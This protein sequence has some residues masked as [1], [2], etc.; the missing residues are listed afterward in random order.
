MTSPYSLNWGDSIYAKVKATNIV[1]DSQ[2]SVEGNGAVILTKPDAPV[3]LANDGATTS[4]TTIAMTWSEGAANGGTPVIDYR[5]KYKLSSDAIYTTLVTGITTT[6]FT[7]TLLKQGS[8]YTFKVESRNAF[9]YSTTFSNEV[10]IL[11]AQVPDAPVTLANNAAVTASTQVGLTWSAGAFNG[12]SPIIDYKLSYDQGTGTWTQFADGIT[13][14]SYTVTGLTPDTVYA[15]KVEARNL[16]GFSLESVEVSVR[17]AGRPGKP[18]APTTVVNGNN[19]DITWTSPI[20]GGSPITAY[21][22]TIR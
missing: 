20:T 19:V 1:G 5:I 2:E 13:T 9:G 21:I 16:I 22:I 12:G 4:A 17:A 14:T 15:F 3:T 10:T 11:Q 8:E 18:S 7:T 6:S